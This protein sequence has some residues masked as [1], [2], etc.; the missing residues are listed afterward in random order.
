MRRSLSVLTLLI[1]AP[2]F[3]VAGQSS[4]SS[5]LSVTHTVFPPAG[6]V[7][8]AVIYTIT[9]RN[10]GPDAGQS[11]VVTDSLPPGV[12]LFSCSST[13]SGICGGSGSDVTVSFSSLNP[14]AQGVITIIG[15]VEC[16]VATGMTLT[17]TIRVTSASGDPTSSNNSSTTSIGAFNQP[18]L[19]ECPNDVAV[20]VPAGQ[21]FAEVGYPEPEFFDKCPGTTLVC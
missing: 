3:L 9:V 2:A 6:L 16:V 1:L 5:D 14:G 4:P 8:S 11:V 20:V 13:T 10:A 21:G 12:S 19:I 17:N 7:A 15:I 18:P